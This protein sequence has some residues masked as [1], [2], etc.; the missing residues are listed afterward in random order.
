[1]TGVPISSHESAFGKALA[2]VWPEF[3]NG[4]KRRATMLPFLTANV[5]TGAARALDLGCGTGCEVI[6]LARNS[7]LDVTANEVDDDLA[8]LAR[9]RAGVLS[10]RIA[11]TGVDWRDLRKAFGPE[12]FDLVFL[13]GN[14]FSLLLSED[15]RRDAAS[16]IYDICRSNGRFVVDIRNFEYILDQ[17][18]S[19]LR[20]W[21]R[22]SGRVIYCGTEIKGIPI[23]IADERVTFGYFTGTGERMGTLDMVPLT[24]VRLIECFTS[25]GFRVHEILSDLVSGLNLDADFFSVVFT[26]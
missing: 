26:K 4:E 11:W 7:Q 8:Y 6:E 13:V 24:I 22:Y 16:Q 9:C 23:A 3:V 25:A 19:I 2:V 1:M 14:S 5:P 12:R 21:F 20:G 10:D 18:E 15:D 17:R